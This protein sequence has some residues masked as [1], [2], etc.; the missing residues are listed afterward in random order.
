METVANSTKRTIRISDL[1]H[2]RD[3]CGVNDESLRLIEKMLAVEIGVR[4]DTVFINGEDDNVLS[5]SNLLLQF[6]ELIDAGVSLGKDDIRFISKYLSENPT[7]AMKEMFGEGARL[8]TSNKQIV[9]RSIAQRGYIYS[10]Q[11]SDVVIGIGP[12]GTGKTYLA[13]AV[14][15]SELLKR[16]TNRIILTRP[17]VEAGES[18]GFLPGDLLEKISPYLRPLYDALYEMLGHDKLHSLME[19]GQIEV[20]PL[21]YMRGRTLNDSFIVLDEAQNSTSE[22]MKMFLTRLGINSKAVITGDITQID[23]PKGRISGLV[24]AKNVLSNVPGIDIIYFSKR[25]VVR[26][27]L[28]EKIIGA[29]EGQEA[30]AEEKS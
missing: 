7:A 30:G 24:E 5:A 20:A 15:V 29:Y 19:Q 12:A 6:N 14:A 11:H 9:P 25:D 26:H 16:K 2:F 10:L 1:S 27:E 21:A 3:L 23:L 8:K 28:V 13:M 17:A 22:Q 4:D 18:L